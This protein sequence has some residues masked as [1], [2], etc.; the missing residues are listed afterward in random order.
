VNAELDETGPRQALAER[1]AAEAARSPALDLLAEAA[2]QRVAE[3]V[4]FV[5]ELLALGG[6][7]P[8]FDLLVVSLHSANPKVRGNAIEAMA[9]GVD[10]ATWRR[11]EPLV[12][13]RT[14]AGLGD[15]EDLVA[16]LQRA[17]STSH[18]IEAIAAA[19]ALRDLAPRESLAGLA[20][21]AIAPDLSPALRESLTRILIGDAGATLVD[22][23]GAVRARPEFA[24]ASIDAQVA[25]ALRAVV[26]PPPEG[27]V[28]LELGA[29]GQQWLSE[30]DIDDVATRYPDLALARLKADDERSYAA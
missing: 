27:G 14:G 15:G 8:D 4:D 10:H 26:D 9:S 2:R 25:L 22:L 11:L 6:R 28:A 1:F 24:A 13:G 30:A 12:Q 23:V 18:G 21:G 7:L 19:Q 17:A 20:R 16:L 3:A 5:L 29:H